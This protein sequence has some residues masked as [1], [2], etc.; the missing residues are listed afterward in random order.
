MSYFNCWS[1]QTD[2]PRWIF[3]ERRLWDSFN[4]SNVPPAINPNPGNVKDLQNE[5]IVRES[6]Y[7]VL[8]VLLD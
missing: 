1:T 4:I 2:F 8:D 6:P 7:K 3:D 5:L